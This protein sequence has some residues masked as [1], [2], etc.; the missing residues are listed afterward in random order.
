M[1]PKLSGYRINALRYLNSFSAKK[2]A[3]YGTIAAKSGIG[4]SDEAQIVCEEFIRYGLAE[5]ENSR[6]KITEFGQQWMD[7]YDE[8]LNEQIREYVYED[9]EYALLRFLY[10]QEVPIY[11]DD[12]PKLLEENAPRN[13]NGYPSMNLL[14]MLTIDLRQ[15]IKEVAGQRYELNDEGKKYVERWAERNNYNIAFTARSSTRAGDE[16]IRAIEL[17][18]PFLSEKVYQDILECLRRTLRRLE[19][20]PDLFAK[21]GEV[22][23]RDY[24]MIGLEDRFE[25][26]TLTRESFN[27]HGKTDILLKHTDST[28]IFVAECKIWTGEKGMLEAID[29]L[30]GYLTWRDSKAALLLFCRTKDF[31]SILRTIATATARHPNFLKSTGSDESSFSN[32]FC[33][34]D[35]VNKHIFLEIVAA[36]FPEGKS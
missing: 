5:F 34:P 19:Q 3:G 26:T 18:D 28:N 25:S 2:G 15:F 32:I 30:M 11:R 23:I 8:A 21:F 17:Q 6:V 31:S 10:H 29:Q 35:D 12:I 13:T 24:I 36:H 4:Y 16:G 9:Y 1:H 33:H 7:A 27:K 14:H 22:D 20:K